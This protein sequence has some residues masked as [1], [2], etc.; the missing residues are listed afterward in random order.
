LAND[1][2]LWL[3]LCRVTA[4]VEAKKLGPHKLDKSIDELIIMHL[5]DKG[6]PKFE[7]HFETKSHIPK[8]FN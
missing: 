6:T 2:A 5:I 1:D 7:F 4:N 8:D 3:D